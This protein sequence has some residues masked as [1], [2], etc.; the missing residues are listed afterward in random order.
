M[1]QSII[2]VSVLCALVFVPNLVI[3]LRNNKR[4]TYCDLDEKEK[5]GTKRITFLGMLF[6]IIVYLICLIVIF[7][8]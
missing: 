4:V 2:V 7:M 5:T 8:L 6:S 3:Y 1:L